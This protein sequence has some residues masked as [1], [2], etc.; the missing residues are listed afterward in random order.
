MVLLQVRIDQVFPIRG[1][2]KGEI[3]FGRDGGKEFQRAL[4]KLNMVR[5]CMR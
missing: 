5:L 1:R 2:V 3:V 4:R